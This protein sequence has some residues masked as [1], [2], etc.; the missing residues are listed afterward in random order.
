VKKDDDDGSD[1]ERIIGECTCWMRKNDGGGAET[2]TSV[3]VSSLRVDEE[4]RRRG[5]GSALLREAERLGQSEFGAKTASLS[6]NKW[7]KA[8]IAMYER[9]GF[10]MEDGRLGGS[11]E[12]LMDP[13]RLVQFRMEKRIGVLDADR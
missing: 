13:L 2:K 7:N 10:E 4:F 1:D 6:V 9:L 5:V 11:L 3:F 12:T 8:A